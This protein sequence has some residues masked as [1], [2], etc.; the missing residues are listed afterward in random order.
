MPKF[1]NILV[2]IDLE[3]D[4]HPALERAARIAKRDAAAITVVAVL[5]PLPKF[6]SLI[7]SE[8]SKDIESVI[9]GEIREKLD[10][11]VAS[12]A[13]GVS[14]V[15]TDLLVGH[16]AI[17]IIRQVLR[18]GHD[19]VIKVGDEVDDRVRSRVSHRD[20][21]LLRKCPC[22]VWLVRIPSSRKIDRVLAAI[23]PEPGDAVRNALNERIMEMAADVSHDEK[24]KLTALRAWGLVGTTVHLG[25]LSQDQ[26][27]A[28]MAKVGE[29]YRDSLDEFFEGLDGAQ[30]DADVQLV[31][32]EAEEVIPEWVEKHGVDVLVM[33]TVARTGIAGFLIGNTAE[34][35]LNQVGCS[36]IALKPQGFVTPVSRDEE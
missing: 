20:M 8:T 23:D 3:S 36:I 30:Q 5:E 10:A 6:A 12:A 17:Q 11:L 19:L 29:T 24:A 16:T 1:T 35:V 28:Y 21:Q 18:G 33:G 14:K 31:K 7:L 26:L 2:C 13:K 25:R 32:G 34:R 9:A 4:D 27:D 15:T 22:T